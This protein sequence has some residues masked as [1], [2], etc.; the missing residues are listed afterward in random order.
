MMKRSWTS[1]TLQFLVPGN[2][3][4]SRRLG[5]ILPHLNWISWLAQIYTWKDLTGISHMNSNVIN[6]LLL[7]PVGKKNLNHWF[8]GLGVDGAKSASR[9]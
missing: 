8:A 4:W 7:V 2:K 6:S 5:F 9:M 3:C 1:N